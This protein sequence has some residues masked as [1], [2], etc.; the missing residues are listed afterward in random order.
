[1]TDLIDSVRKQG[2]SIGG[3][4]EIRSMGVPA[5][6]G[7]PVFDKIDAKL[8]AAIMS[9]GGVRGFEIGSGFSIAEKKVPK[10]M[11]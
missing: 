1:M 6:L 11:I 5:G 8:A 2:D 3:I 10:L 7:S 4:I 9:I